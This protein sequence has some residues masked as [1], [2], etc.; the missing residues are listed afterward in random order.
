MSATTAPPLGDGRQIKPSR[1]FNTIVKSRAF[2]RILFPIAF[3]VIWWLVYYAIRSRIFPPP[4]VVLG[5]MWD[6]ITLNTPL[7]YGSIRSNVY[8]M[9]AI[10]LARLGI[11]FIIAMLLGTIIGLAM[12]LSKAV[13]AFFH[14]W[15][16]AILAM[17][18]LVW[19]LFLGI[20]LGFGHDGPIIAVAL[21]GLPFVVINVREGVRNTPKDLFDMARSFQ[22]PR[23]R[24]IQHV[25]LPSL[26]PFMFAAARYGFAIGW[27]GL[28][29]TEVFASD[30]GAG[31]TIKFWYDA[32]QA[33]GVIGY[34]LFFILFALFL[35][36][37]IFERLERM[38]FKW[39]PSIQGLAV[40][41]QPFDEFDS[42]DQF[43]ARS[44]VDASMTNPREGDNRRG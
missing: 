5:F 17:P 42:D 31:W 29:I 34:A 21:T 40:P 20:A 35:E 33:R 2:A 18:A 10:S 15:I 43:D 23:K 3:L 12:G 44:T 32:H 9:F 4:Q 1:T 22:V 7:R 28:V 19:A 24:I 8:G 39:R 41:E 13:D 6:E 26:M 27:K 16:M 25:L 11:G 36:R 38:A 14:D 37:T 30:E